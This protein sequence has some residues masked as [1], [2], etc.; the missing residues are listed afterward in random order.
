MEAWLSAA[1]TSLSSSSSVE[2][3]EESLHL[4]SA[5]LHPGHLLLLQLKQKLAGL[6]GSSPGLTRPARERRLQLLMDLVESNSKV[7]A[8]VFCINV[9]FQMLREKDIFRK[10]FGFGD[11]LELIGDEMFPLLRKFRIIKCQGSPRKVLSLYVGITL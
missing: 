8:Q 2:Q 6:Y 3:C 7:S 5:R 10:V 1:Q 9:A 4:L 11:I